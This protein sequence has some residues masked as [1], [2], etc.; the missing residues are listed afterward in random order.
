MEI[1]LL[2]GH[3]LQTIDL[4]TAFLT[5]HTRESLKE[6]CN[7]FKGFNRSITKEMTWQLATNAMYEIRYL[8][9]TDDK[10]GYKNIYFVSNKERAEYYHKLRNKLW[11]ML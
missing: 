1:T 3:T 9:R 8:Y 10:F 7:T 2:N 5:N 11:H 4:V 6:D